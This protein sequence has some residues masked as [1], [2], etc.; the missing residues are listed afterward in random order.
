MIG[1]RPTNS[2][3]AATHLNPL[4]LRCVCWPANANYWTTTHEQTAES[5]RG[6]I[7]AAGGHLDEAGRVVSPLT[8][9]SLSPGRAF[10]DFDL[11]V[12]GKAGYSFYS[13]V[14]CLTCRS[15]SS[16]QFPVALILAEPV[17]TPVPL[18]DSAVFCAM[19]DG[20]G[21]PL[22]PEQVVAARAAAAIHRPGL[23]LAA[24]AADVVARAEQQWPHLF[25]GEEVDNVSCV[26]GRLRL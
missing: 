24:A 8:G 25:P 23:G 26:L 5:E 21:D 14:P 15:P 17:V 18:A 19:S 16:L 10:G 20:V 13:V 6:R 22:S 12:R 9:S 1:Q 3:S 4:C 2:P 11:K 7:E